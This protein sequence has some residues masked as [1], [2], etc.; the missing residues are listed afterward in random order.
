[1]NSKH[2]ELIHLLFYEAEKIKIPL[3]LS[4]GWAIDAKRGQV[5]WEHEDIDVTYPSDQGNNFIALLLRLGGS[6]TQQTSYG[7]LAS[8][9]GVLIDCEPCT[10]VGD[11]YELD[12]PPSG[13]CPMEKLGKLDS[14]P[15]RCI[16]WEA[17]LW[18]YF[19]YIEEVPLSEW[20][21]KD[22]SNFELVK[23]FYG[24]ANT[25]K[26]YEQFKTQCVG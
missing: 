21:S 25:Q 7:F 6:I 15:I 8:L 11:S 16:S 3:W 1:M 9:Q 14:I 26:L 23:A 18:D 22:F 10:L 24:K 2:I 12:G 4:G 19:Y 17:V 13:A 20:R 5:T